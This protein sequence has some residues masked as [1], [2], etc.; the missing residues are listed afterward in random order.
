[1]RLLLVPNSTVVESVTKDHAL[2]KNDSIRVVY[3]KRKLQYA[4]FVLIV[5]KIRIAAVPCHVES[6]TKDHT[7]SKNDY[8]RVVYSKCKLQ[9]AIFVLIVLKIRIAAVP[10]H[11]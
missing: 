8:I 5:L 2:S 7:F 1:M 10:C 6:V 4:I 9:Y 11:D 3:S